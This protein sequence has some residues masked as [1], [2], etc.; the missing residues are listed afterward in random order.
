M[1]LVKELHDSMDANDSR[2]VRLAVS[3]IE[4][5]DALDASRVQLQQEI[6][7]G[8]VRANA[9]QAVIQQLRAKIQLHDAEEIASR[10]NDGLD[11][12]PLAL[13]QD[14]RERLV[15]QIA[16][17]Q[18]AHEEA[19]SGARAKGLLDDLHAEIAVLRLENDHLRAALSSAVP[20]D[21]GAAPMI[22]AEEPTCDSEGIQEIPF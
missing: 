22:S 13:Y 21:L 19:M 1:D 16:M 9:A 4:T 14:L 10:S 15:R 18:G 5:T 11:R 20:L 8:Q 7:M 6:G 3:L 12:V 2:A 17:F